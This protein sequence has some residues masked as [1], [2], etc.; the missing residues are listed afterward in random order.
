MNF[1][2]LICLQFCKFTIMRYKLQSVCCRLIHI[3]HCLAWRVC[4]CWDILEFAVSIL[5]SV[6]QVTLYSGWALNISYSSVTS[7]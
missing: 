1:F 5:F 3:T 7:L 6:C 2:N 4:L